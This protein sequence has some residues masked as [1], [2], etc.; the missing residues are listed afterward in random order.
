MR[1]QID[2]DVAI[3]TM[4]PSG[5]EGFIRESTRSVDGGEG[6]EIE[7]CGYDEVEFVVIGLVLF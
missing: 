2:K 1:Y 4:S 5:I 6:V 3:E 7:V